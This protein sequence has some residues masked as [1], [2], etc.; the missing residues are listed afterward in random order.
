MSEAF[1]IIATPVFKITLRKLSSFLSSK[2]GKDSASQALE[3]IKQRVISLSDNPNLGPV[4]ER[5]EA[6]GFVN[7]RQLSVDSHNIVFYRVDSD[8]K[9]IILVAAMDSRQ[10]LEQLL[11]EVTI[12]L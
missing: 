4:S 12:A 1:E 10:S 2:Y 8:L 9:K 5:L 7:Y 6:M 11:Y 3:K